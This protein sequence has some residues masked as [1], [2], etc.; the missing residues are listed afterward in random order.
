MARNSD[1]EIHV[2]CEEARVASEQLEI[3]KAIFSFSLILDS[4]LIGLVI[5]LLGFVLQ[6]RLVNAVRMEIKKQVIYIFALLWL[7][8][9][10][11]ALSFFGII[12]KDYALYCINMILSALLLLCFVSYSIYLFK[13]INRNLGS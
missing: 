10:L 12:T 8:L 6:I 13:R 2:C 7:S 9:L 1:K 5:F 11:S 4:I 3:V